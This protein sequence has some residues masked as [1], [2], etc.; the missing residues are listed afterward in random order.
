MAEN[1]IVSDVVRRLIIDGYLDGQKYKYLSETFRLSINTIK[2]IVHR[3]KKFGLERKPRGHRKKVLDQEQQNQLKEWC[4]LDCQRTLED[5][6]N[7]IEDKYGIKVSKSTINNYLDSLHYTIKRTSVVPIRRN[8]DSTINTRYEYAM[9]F[10]LMDRNREKIYFL[11]ECGVSVSTRTNYGRSLRGT[12]ANLTVKSIRGKNYSV[13]AAM[14]HTSLF[15]YQVQETAYNT[16]NFVDY[17]RQ[18]LDHLDSFNVRSAYIVMDNVRFH[19]SE[20]VQSLVEARGHHLEFLPPYSPFLNPIENLFNQLKF[21][22][23]RMRP[24]T[25]DKVH[26]AVLLASDCVTPIDC[27]NYYGKML[28]YIPKC[29]EKLDIQN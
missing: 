3:Y 23:K 20:D 14:N 21:Y 18:F 2:S 1:K 11:D 22:V 27:S 26:E 7:L 13:C 10:M 12:R 17:L 16:P 5:Y 15:F 29:I 25:S 4:D 8:C 28:E 24:E 9:K 19:H 6:S